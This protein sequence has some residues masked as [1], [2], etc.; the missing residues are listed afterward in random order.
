MLTLIEHHRDAIAR[1]I[2]NLSGLAT[3][4]TLSDAHHVAR[5]KILSDKGDVNLLRVQGREIDRFESDKSTFNLDDCTAHASVLTSV[6]TDF[7]TLHVDSLAALEQRLLDGGLER[8]VS[9]IFI[10]MVV[11]F[12]RAVS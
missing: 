6:H 10:I 5:L 2:D 1:H 8:V 9:L 4:F 7:V 12:R 3:I 11:I